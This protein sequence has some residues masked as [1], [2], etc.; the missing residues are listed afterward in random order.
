[1]LGALVH[2]RFMLA[3]TLSRAMT[4]LHSSIP[5]RRYAPPLEDEYRVADARIVAAV[6][7]MRR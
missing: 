5:R 3:R 1:L 4:L 7:A 2:Q 6:R